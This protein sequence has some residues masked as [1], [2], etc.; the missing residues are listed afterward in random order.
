MLLVIWSAAWAYRVNT[1]HTGRRKAG[2]SADEWSS[3]SGQDNGPMKFLL[4]AEAVMIILQ[5]ATQFVA[6]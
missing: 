3:H 2:P 4:L 1:P 5:S 6:H